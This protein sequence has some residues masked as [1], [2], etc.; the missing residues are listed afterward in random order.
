MNYGVARSLSIE[1]AY[2]VST[3]MRATKGPA[4]ATPEAAQ[5]AGEQ[6]A[7]ARSEC[8]RYLNFAHL[9]MVRPPA[10]AR[11]PSALTRARRSCATRSALRRATF[12]TARTSGWGA[13]SG[14]TWRQCPCCV[15][16]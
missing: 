7:F 10:P 9:L 6:N 4:G 3:N 1:L 15:S 14:S 12:R 5:L 16:C 11:Q 13:S 2:I 8:M